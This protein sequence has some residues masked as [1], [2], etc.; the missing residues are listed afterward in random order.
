M[1]GVSVSDKWLLEGCGVLPLSDVIAHDDD[2]WEGFSQYKRL[3]CPLCSDTFQHVETHQRILGR[4]DYEA[5][6][7]GRGD[8]TVVPIWGECEHRWEL[9]FGFHKG[10]TFCFVRVS[11]EQKAAA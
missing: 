6:W 5:G 10:Q 4:D 3:R 8:L 2:L 1:P 11:Y 9:C 7:G